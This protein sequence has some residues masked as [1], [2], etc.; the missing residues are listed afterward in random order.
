MGEAE[1]VYVPVRF[2][3]DYQPGESLQGMLRSV[4]K[5]EVIE[6]TPWLAVVFMELGYAIWE[7]K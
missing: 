3:R 2:I 5:G 1:E 4:R 7:G 6:V